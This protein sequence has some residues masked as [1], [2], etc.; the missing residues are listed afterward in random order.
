M[1]ST[2]LF[3]LQYFYPSISVLQ[4]AERYYVQ[5]GLTKEAIDMY[6]NAGK[7]EAA[8]KVS[9][10]IGQSILIQNENENFNIKGVLHP[11]LKISMFCVIFQNYQHFFFFFFFGK[12]M[13]AS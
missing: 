2:L 12:I 6:T 10:S 9:R 7:W 11:K 8:H 1:Y 13:H 5:A 3:M 4:R